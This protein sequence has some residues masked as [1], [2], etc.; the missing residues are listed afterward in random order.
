[1]QAGKSGNCQAVYWV[2]E[3]PITTEVKRHTKQEK[4]W[5]TGSVYKGEVGCCA[6]VLAMAQVFV[7]MLTAIM[8]VWRYQCG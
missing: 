8:F 3:R 6:C 4:H 7:T 2:K 1:M 5:Q